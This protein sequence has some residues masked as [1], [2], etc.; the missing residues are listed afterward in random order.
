MF[1]YFNFLSS[2]FWTDI[3]SNKFLLEKKNFF[4]FLV[5]LDFINT[6][7]I[8][9]I[10][11]RNRLS[12]CLSVC[13]QKSVRTQNVSVCLSVCLHKKCPNTVFKWCPSVCLFVC[14]KESEHKICFPMKGCRRH[15]NQRVPIMCSDLKLD[16]R[17]WV[18]KRT[19]KQT[20]KQ[21]DRVS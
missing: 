9:I 1:T 6:A 21:T 13:L 17:K 11:S 20:E 19:N 4:I 10:I 12:I 3:L 14:K 8:Y 18:K 15:P 7:R 16:H 2:L 5:L